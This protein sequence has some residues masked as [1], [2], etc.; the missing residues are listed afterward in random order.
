[1]GN[2]D[3]KQE[4]KIFYDLDSWLKSAIGQNALKHDN[5]NTIRELGFKQEA[6]TG[7]AIH[8]L[9]KGLREVA[10]WAQSN[11]N[12]YPEIKSLP[13]NKG[14]KIVF[15]PRGTDAKNIQDADCPFIEITKTGQNGSYTIRDGILSPNSPILVRG[16]NGEVGLASVMSTEIAQILDDWKENDMRI[17]QQL[18][19]N[20]AEGLKYLK[21]M[22]SRS[23]SSVKQLTAGVYSTHQIKE[24]TELN[25]KSVN[26]LRPEALWAMMSQVLTGHYARQLY[27]ANSSKRG[28]PTLQQFQRDID[29]IMD[30]SRGLKTAQQISNYVK[31]HYGWIYQNVWKGDFENVFN[32]FAGKMSQSGM[33]EGTKGKFGLMEV[34]AALKAFQA[35]GKKL[36]QNAQV[37]PQKTSFLHGKA[38]AATGMTSVMSKNQLAKI[39]QGIKNGFMSNNDIFKDVYTTAMFSKQDL[40]NAKKELKRLYSA[41][42]T[43]TGAKEILERY[44]LSVKQFEKQYDK[45]VD[46][47]LKG[48][49]SDASF[50]GVDLARD[51]RGIRDPK[52]LK[53]G[54]IT[55]D[56]L[57][58]YVRDSILESKQRK[59]ER[60]KKD[61]H[62]KNATQKIDQINKEIA[63]FS[64]DGINVLEKE[65]SGK[66]KYGQYGVFDKLQN[67]VRKIYD[68]DNTYKINNNFKFQDSLLTNLVATRARHNDTAVFR[69]GLTADERTTKSMMSNLLMAESMYQAKYNPEDIFRDTTQKLNNGG[70]LKAQNFIES[71]PL[72]NKNIRSRIMQVLTHVNSELRDQRKMQGED[73][74]KIFKEDEFFGKFFK[75]KGKNAIFSI[76]KETGMLLVDNDALEARLD[77]K[78]KNDAEMA[79]NMLLAAVRVGQMAGVYDPNVEYFKKRRGAGTTWLTQEAPILLKEELG[80]SSSPEW[81]NLGRAGGTR[82]RIGINEMRSL[83]AT[84][85]EFGQWLLDQGYTSGNKNKDKD[86]DVA[87]APIR[88]YVNAVRDK[89]EDNKAKYHKYV[90]NADYL[91]KNFSTEASQ[92]RQDILDDM[93]VVKLDVNDLALMNFDMDYDAVDKG[94][95]LIKDGDL[96]TSNLIGPYLARKRKERF[97]QIQA[98]KKSKQWNDL[99][100]LDKSK[101]NAIN[102]EDDLKMFALD[103]GNEHL[104][105]EINGKVYDSRMMVLPIGSFDQDRA[106]IYKPDEGLKTATSMLRSARDFLIHDGSFDRDKQAYF[107]TKNIIEQLKDWQKE[108]TGGK[109]FEAAHEVTGGR[110]SGYLLLQ[111]MTD[112]SEEI[113]KDILGSKGNGANLNN[114]SRIIST[115]DLTEML[116]AE[117]REDESKVIDLYQSIFKKGPGKKSRDGIIKAIVD[118][119]DISKRGK[120]GKRTWNGNILNNLWSNRNPTINFINDLV[121]GGLVASSNADLVAQGRMLINKHYAAIGKGDMD[122]DL[123]TLF[124]A[125]NSGDFQTAG[126]A[127]S[128]FFT[129]KREYQKEIQEEEA[130]ADA[131]NLDAI[132]RNILRNNPQ[133]DVSNI[134]NAGEIKKINSVLDKEEKDVTVAAAWLGKQ[135]AGRYGNAKFSAEDIISSVVGTTNRQGN[136]IT[137]FGA[138]V[139]GAIIQSLYQKGI[140]IKNLKRGSN[141]E[142]LPL[143]E[144]AGKVYG[145]MLSTMDMVTGAGTWDDDDIRR[146]FFD[147]AEALGVF[148]NEA[149]FE[150]ATLQTLGLDRITKKDQKFLSDLKTIAENTK[151]KLERQF[152]PNSEQ[153]K[154]IETDIKQI[155]KVQSGKQKTI[156]NL[157]KEFVNAIVG[158]DYSQSF[159]RAVGRDGKSLGYQMSKTFEHIEGYSSSIGN[160]IPAL[161][162]VI[163]KG[164]YDEETLHKF[165]NFFSTAQNNKQSNYLS[166]LRLLEKYKGKYDVYTSPSSEL[167]QFFV[168]DKE[169]IQSDDRIG[170]LAAR[171]VSATTDE[172]R[173]KIQREVN[174]L[175]PEFRESSGAIDTIRGL[176]AHKV[177]EVLALDENKN[178]DI[179]SWQTGREALNLLDDKFINPYKAQLE[180]M[181]DTFKDPKTME[182]F[183]LNA[184]Q[185]GVGNTRLLRSTMQRTAGSGKAISLGSETPL[186]GYSAINE[187]GYHKK[188][189]QTAD[190]MWVTED[191]NGL[192]L[193]VGDFKNP[194][195]DHVGIQN[196]IQ[197]ADEAR[198]MEILSEHVQSL[199]RQHGTPISDA[200]L[201]FSYDTAIGRDWQARLRHAAAK[202]SGQTSGVEYQQAYEKILQDFETKLKYARQGF[203]RTQGHL[204]TSGNTGYSSVYD[205]RLSDPKLRQM[206]GAYLDPSKGLNNAIVYNSEAANEVLNSSVTR[207][208]TYFAGTFEQAK[209]Q[210]SGDAQKILERYEVLQTVRAA[211]TDLELKEQALHRD[212]STPERE[213][214]LEEL[215]EQIKNKRAEYAEGLNN[216]QKDAEALG[217]K[218]IYNDQGL[219]LQGVGKEAVLDPLNALITQT[220][221]FYKDEKHNLEQRNYLDSL[222][223]HLGQFE[224]QAKRVADLEAK[225]KSPLLKGKNKAAARADA[226]AALGQEKTN[227]E[228][229]ITSIEEERGGLDKDIEGQFINPYTLEAFDEETGNALDLNRD[230]DKIYSKARK[231]ARQ[232]RRVSD[233]GQIAAYEEAVLSYE[234]QRYHFEDEIAAKEEEKTEAENEGLTEKVELLQLEID[235]LKEI[236][237]LTLGRAKNDL[238]AMYGA[239]SESYKNMTR[240]QELLHEQEKNKKKPTAPQQQGGGGSGFMGID[241][242]TSRWFERL[243]NGGIIFTA[244]RL[245]R[246]GFHDLTNKAKQLDQAMTN[247]RIVTGKS[248]D[249]ARILIDN[250]AELGK[251]LGATTV[252]VTAAATSWLRQGYDISQVNDL[253]TSSLYLSKLGM[254]DVATATQNMTSAM[255]G[256]QLEASQAMD[257]VDKLTA[258]D[259]KAA[260]TA[261]DIAQGLS[262]F[263]NIARLGGVSIDQAAAYVATIADVNQMSGITVGQ[264]LNFYGDLRG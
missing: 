72:S 39:R 11:Y 76:D 158:G 69:A 120:D 180:F 86:Y 25:D 67:Y 37:L 156:T 19:K 97:E 119:V 49:G 203:T 136:N 246:R 148:K 253:V 225:V 192:T 251:E 124:D 214:A 204:I 59:L 62:G 22:T 183:L 261:G 13:G 157:S 109:T 235:H 77:A 135:G 138:R 227:L 54:F 166:E 96:Q 111:G 200:N 80:L 244:I 74:A 51:L 216:I 1:M 40:E 169:Y 237:E 92:F 57:N 234:K 258:L 179:N 152:G 87:I 131:K 168:N 197:L 256:F 194:K 125:L 122:G 134:T 155:A 58:N 208:G 27:N 199:Q 189:Y 43:D 15:R 145:Q 188:S 206:F 60:L 250:Y 98:L 24:Y 95:M 68:L 103:F 228:K 14:A 229:L 182:K 29:N 50:M 159:S 201:F 127:L 191:E 132:K 167:K 172:E 149:M 5:L 257:I 28:A 163:G 44:G 198:S 238:D 154:T 205:V 220:D 263:A 34:E 181:S 165:A 240:L 171:Y 118:S 108:I 254:I 48:F 83:E 46:M 115:T 160:L 146:S 215:R 75:E 207:T 150:G 82:S 21:R 175:A 23:V 112:N 232:D 36:K 241:S 64:K 248:A 230:I 31:Q 245:I 35:P 217:S 209:S 178:M 91:A 193:H 153:V 113:L 63:E 47:M 170:K 161:G 139:F 221:S 53:D 147:R 2:N 3:K 249:N 126:S 260:T 164:Q 130:K 116:K 129:H 212:I 16:S 243:A 41:R 90:E 144:E 213:I 99:S 56:E 262:Q 190:T 101:Y 195:K 242:A 55:F 81:M 93:S 185:K 210:L 211:L 78:H 196:V 133:A 151:F 45:S 4:A 18:S 141:G 218:A 33:T 104:S 94:G 259:V 42:K 8:N 7:K 186:L 137:S 17:R 264:S 219:Q 61:P 38:L 79:T 85:G 12:L 187:Q 173:E 223:K 140:N 26:N 226:R 121:G 231:R 102:S 236:K 107:S 162:E 73:I 66:F 20:K 128:S 222:I 143:D 89:M 65:A 106:N 88:N 224:T 10:A 30:A 52:H 239:N 84:Y 176:I 9:E 247:L 252:E 110:G 105:T 6:E 32:S 117:I 100:A 70:G 123:V 233:R 202:E 142:I 177:A 174:A 255:H 114:V 184:A 71:A